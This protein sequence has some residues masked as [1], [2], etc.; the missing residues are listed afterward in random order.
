MTDWALRSRALDAP[1]LAARQWPHLSGRDV[2]YRDGA[3]RGP[4]RVEEE[5]REEKRE[6]KDKGRGELKASVLRRKR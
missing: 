6:K 5:E 1:L 3:G 4:R 2:L